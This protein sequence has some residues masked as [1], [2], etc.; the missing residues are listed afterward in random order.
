LTQN[1]LNLPLFITKCLLNRGIGYTKQLTYY[2]LHNLKYLD[3]SIMF[4]RSQSSKP[5]F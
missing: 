1:A 3:L 2:L 5:N 4:G